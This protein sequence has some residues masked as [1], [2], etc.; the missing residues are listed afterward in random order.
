ML[1]AG[2]PTAHATWHTDPAR[3][4]RRAAALGAPVVVKA[5][6]LAAGKGVVVA[7]TPA[8][9]EAAIDDMLVATASAR[10]GRRCWSRSS[11]RARSCR[12]ST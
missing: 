8:E 10:R 1:D 2:V 5:S 11:W 4:K 12:C 7:H 3:A 9:A 6:G